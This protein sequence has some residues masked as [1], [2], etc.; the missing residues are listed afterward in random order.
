MRYKDIVDELNNIK[1]S[2]LEIGY[3]LKKIM[4]PELN[5]IQTELINVF[6]IKI[7]DMI[8]M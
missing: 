1:T 7:E 5:S 4:I 3:K 6:N 8:K 2:E